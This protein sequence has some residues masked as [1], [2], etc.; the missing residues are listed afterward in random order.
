MESSILLRGAEPVSPASSSRPSASEGDGSVWRSL[1]TFLA[2]QQDLHFL[3]SLGWYGCR[4]GLNSFYCATMRAGRVV[5]ASL[6]RARRIPGT[7]LTVYRVERGPVAATPEDLDVHLRLMCDDLRR[8]AALVS[9]SPHYYGARGEAY[10]SVLKSGGWRR[11]P[12]IL[13]N[14]QATIVVNLTEDIEQI[15]GKLRRSLRTQLNRGARLGIQIKE[16][17]DASAIATFVEQHDAMARRRGLAPIPGEVT[18]CLGDRSDSARSLLRLLIAE[19]EGQ[20]IAGILLVRAGDR[21]IYEWGVT[22]EE[23]GHR[24]LPLSHMLHWEAIGWAKSAGYHYYDLGGYWEE[25]GDEDP[26]NRFKT[27]FSKEVQRFVP[28][29]YYPMRPL[30]AGALLGLASLRARIMS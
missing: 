15:R 10:E 22:S 11:M 26:I 12:T 5:A 17:S 14:Y 23:E 8:D 3:Q 13:S 21:A 16:G 1:D 2:S 6:V 25:R 9:V 7:G 28:E 18:R 30:L 4:D 29:Y 24:Q 20:Q 27:G 19:Y